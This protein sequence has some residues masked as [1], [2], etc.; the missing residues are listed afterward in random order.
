MTGHVATMEEGKSSFKILTGKP[1][2]RM[3]LERSRH[4]WV[5]N[6]RIDLKGKVI[7]TKNWVDSALLNVA[8]NPWVP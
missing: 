1:I 6:I 5:D 2:G 8:L 3:P 7:N 4:R